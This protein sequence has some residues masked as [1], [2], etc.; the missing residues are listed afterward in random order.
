MQADRTPFRPGWK[1]F[2]LKGYRPCKSTYCLFDYT[3]L[4][5]LDQSLFRGTLQWLTP[6]D[7]PLRQIMQKYW[8]TP[9]DRKQVLANFHSLASRAEQ[10]NLQLPEAFMRLMGTPDLQERIPSCTAC[11]FDLPDRIVE[12]PFGDGGYFIRFL[13][14]Q[15][16]VLLWHLYLAPNGD[17]CV[18]VSSEAFDDGNFGQRLTASGEQWTPDV[19]RER[20]F[21]CAPAFED[22]L[23]RFWIENHIWF[24]LN[25]GYALTEE[26]H[27][28]LRQLTAN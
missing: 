28:Y 8:P 13:N 2:E 26:Q 23:Y 7:A 10:M 6:L 19:I 16:W 24:V 22:F 1:S 14:D 12:S 17:H 3:L 20:T 4:P 9:E 18:V 21:F 25:K 11:Y 27:H 5:S 15:Q